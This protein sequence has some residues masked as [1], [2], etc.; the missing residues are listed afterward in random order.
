MESRTPLLMLFVSCV[1]VTMVLA[2]GDIDVLS[3]LT[4]D[5]DSCIGYQNTTTITITQYNATLTHIY[6]RTY[7]HYRFLTITRTQ[8]YT[9]PLSATATWIGIGFVIGALVASLIF[10]IKIERGRLVIRKEVGKLIKRKK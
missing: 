2:I 5:R 7:T 9:P 3:A 8:T 10:L 4:I 6:V 1:L